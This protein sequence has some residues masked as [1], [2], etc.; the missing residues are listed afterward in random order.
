MRSSK[1]KNAHRSGRAEIRVALKEALRLLILTSEFHT[2][3]LNRLK[4]TA[5]SVPQPT[6]SQGRQYKAIVVLFLAGAADSFNMIV[7]HS[8]C[9]GTHDLHQEYLDVRTNVALEKSS[10][11]EINVPHQPCNKF[12]I[13]P[14]FSRADARV[15]HTK[16][17]SG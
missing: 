5:R 16:A 11:L 3:V 7:P 2:T 13:H 8:E 14:S 15:T 4:P 12:G 10:L 1:A 6:V 17:V 9:G